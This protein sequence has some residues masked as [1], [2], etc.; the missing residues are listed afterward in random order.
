MDQADP[1]SMQ[2]IVLGTA[3]DGGVP[4]AGCY[5]ANCAAAR[6][7]PER[8]R[9]VACLG[10]VDRSTGKSWMIDA[11]P[12]LPE[13]LHILQEFA[14]ECELSGV[15]LTHAHIGHYAGLVHLGR[16]AMDTKGM[17]IYATERMAGFLR[18]NEPWSSLV[19]RSNMA[20]QGIIPDEPVELGPGLRITPVNVPHRDELSDTVAYVI[21]G[22]VKRV[23]YCPDIDSW[24]DWDRDVREFV[25]GMDI[26]LIDGTFSGPDELE[27]REVRDVPHPLVADTVERLEGVECDVHL[28]HLN[29]TN[30]L[31]GAGP[32]ADLS[33]SSGVMVCSEGDSFPL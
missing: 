28:I 12:D 26:A 24:D 4:Q 21:E 17:P 16:E 27:G 14:P 5:C 31:L 9:L 19:D 33:S 10:L 20:I 11:T 15:L 22:P 25:S 3:Q 7:V 2:A 23:F 18:G 32:A 1:T 6:A 30:R 29:H 8:R 13:Q